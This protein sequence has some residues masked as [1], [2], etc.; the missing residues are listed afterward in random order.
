[1]PI[2]GY[3]CNKC[4]HNFEIEQKIGDSKKKKCPEC[5][6]MSLQRVFY[7]VG[8][9]FRGKGFHTT[10]YGNGSKT[11]TTKPKSDVQDG[12]KTSKD[13]NAIKRKK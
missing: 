3:K 12:G 2:Y 9:H 4:D 1:M 7:P 11:L 10:D 5:K 8:V 6:K 13:V